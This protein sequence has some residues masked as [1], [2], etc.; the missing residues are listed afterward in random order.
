[1]YDNLYESP[2]GYFGVG[3]DIRWCGRWSG[4]KFC[5]YCGHHAKFKEWS[6]DWH[7]YYLLEWRDP[8]WGRWGW[9]EFSHFSTYSFYN[10][11]HHRRP[12]L[13]QKYI[14]KAKR[15]RTVGIKE[16]DLK[17]LLKHGCKPKRK[18]KCVSVSQRG[19][20]YCPECFYLI[21]RMAKH[22][23]DHFHD[24]TIMDKNE[25]KEDILIFLLSGIL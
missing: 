25:L 9:K 4:S 6:K 10:T 17:S 13:G 20:W 1:M 2:F 16:T 3:S 11:I 23:G 18:C 21:T 8:D 14:A 15:Y 24:L 22:R 5:M 7:W 19:A 12:L